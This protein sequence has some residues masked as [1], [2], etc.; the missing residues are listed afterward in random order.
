MLFYQARAGVTGSDHFVYEVTD[1]SGAVSG[2][3]V[4]ITIREPPKKGPAPN[5]DKPILT[6]QGA[7]KLRGTGARKF[8]VDILR[9][10]S[11]TTPGRNAHE[12]GPKTF[13]HRNS[14]PLSI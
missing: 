10:V 5:S 14:V 13:G 9:L 12:Y 11:P 6:R 8:M 2:Y 1:V 7:P 4:T 3:D